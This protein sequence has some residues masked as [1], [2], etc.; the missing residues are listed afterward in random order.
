MGPL[1]SA[2]QCGHGTANFIIQTIDTHH[3]DV[4]LLLGVE[5]ES[6]QSAEAAR[7]IFKEKFLEKLSDLPLEL[8]VWIC[9]NWDHSASVNNQRM[10]GDQELYNQIV[11]SAEL[12]LVQN[13]SASTTKW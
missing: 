13:Y 2:R 4:K 7:V 8:R 3:P 11:Q 12:E 10:A 6:L 1:Y 9:H 5:K